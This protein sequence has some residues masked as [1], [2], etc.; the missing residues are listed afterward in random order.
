MSWQDD[1][2]VENVSAS[3]PPGGGG[4]W[5][6]N[7]PVSEAPAG[8]PKQDVG[9]ATRAA[10]AVN[11]GAANV[12]GFPATV[13]NTLRQNVSDPLLEAT[14]SPQARALKQRA[15]AETGGDDSGAES[16]K[17]TITAGG[18]LVGVNTNPD[19]PTPPKNL[20]EKMIDTG[21]EAAGEAMMMGGA[22][23]VFSQALGASETLGK[24][25]L[26]IVK[27]NGAASNAVLGATSGAGSE[28]A[29]SVADKKLPEG[30]TLF[31]SETAA[32]LLRETAPLAGGLAGGSVGALAETGARKG[33]SL[34]ANALR[35]N[36]GNVEKSAARKILGST[37]NPQTLRGQ[38]DEFMEAPELVPGSKPTLFQATGDKGVGTLER[39]IRT[40]NPGRFADVLEGQGVARTNAVNA[41]AEG[42][43]QKLVAYVR[44]QLDNIE[45]EHAAGVAALR[46]EAEQGAAQTGGRTFDNIADY[47]SGMRK[48][49]DELDGQRRAAESKLWDEFREAGGNRPVS[50]DGFKKKI[51]AIRADI[52]PLEGPMAATEKGIF[53]TILGTS[54][55][56]SFKSLGRFRSRLTDAIRDPEELDGS[57]RRRLRQMLGA[58]DETLDNEVAR[59]ASDPAARSPLLDKLGLG[60]LTPED[61]ALYG[62]AKAAT[63]AR[64]ETFGEG[65]VGDVL[66]PGP[67]RGL[68]NTT[69]SLVPGKLLNKPEDLRNFV[70]AAGDDPQA[71]ALAQDYLAFDMRKNATQDGLISPARLQGWMAD[72]AEAMN[73]F[74][75]LKA[76]FETA[77]KAQEALDA[78][79]AN[80]KAALEEFQTAAVK[81]FLAD[82]DPHSALEEA[83]RTP[84]SFRQFVDM[85]RSDKDAFAGLKRLAV[86]LILKKGG[87]AAEEGALTGMKEAGTS[88][89]PQLA[90]NAVQRFFL[91]KRGLL[92]DLFDK[93]ELGNIAA[94]TQ[95]MQRAAR[96]VQIP[97]QSNTAQDMGGVLKG[98]L[99]GAWNK[100][101]GMI[102]GGGSAGLYTMDPT[103][104]IAG[105]AVGKGVDAWRTYYQGRVDRA[106]ADMMLDPRKFAL[107]APKIKESAPSEA[108]LGRRMRALLGQEIAQ[109]L[110]RR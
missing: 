75:G 29:K 71:M 28:A 13:A 34:A 67:R 26:D 72:N 8:A 42:E 80:Q 107:M 59:V 66:E 17:K 55:F 37:E 68:F 40:A 48:R 35:D 101:G 110:D 91:D 30:A 10:M 102:V 104:A 56:S 69:E 77:G 63:R 43:P 5:W 88:G 1:P 58:L 81:K 98:F 96:T 94:V 54:D 14:L 11:R 9:L 19:S 44:G 84:E 106:V 21:G 87:V 6:Q 4:N 22:A 64:K 99:S 2:V 76:R 27:G 39:D 78:A 73:Q 7:D 103:M 57:A 65:A 20:I 32:N 85:V 83:M 53:D 12:L 33:A 79:I 51:D 50:I 16:I 15:Y 38:V 97:G 46:Q 74:P 41:T 89:S 49:L 95:D 24:F 31:G 105:A 100:A 25:M 23:K 108:T 62:E 70:K 86:E 3:G 36:F 82:K 45:A 93:T 52:D 47:G 92:A 61:V 90:A 109:E 60:G 18:N